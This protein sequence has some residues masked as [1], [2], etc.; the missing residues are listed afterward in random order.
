M[1]RIYTIIG[2]LGLIVVILDQITKQLAL[3][4]LITEGRSI[5]YM[6]HWN[7]TLVYNHGAAFGMLRNLPDSIRVGFFIVLPFVVLGLLWWFY[8]RQFK[9]GELVGPLAVG[10]VFGG[11]IG[12]LIDR[13]RFGYVVDFVDWYYYSSSGSCLPLFFAGDDRTCHWPVFNVADAAINVAMV[14]LI[15]Q[16]FWPQKKTS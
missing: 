4:T 12:N 8:V 6:G 13:I 9:V 10:L 11:A 1:K 15:A 3:D 5:R 14:A 2:I 7:W 16:G